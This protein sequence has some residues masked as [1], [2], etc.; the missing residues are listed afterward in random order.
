MYREKVKAFLEKRKET[1]KIELSEINKLLLLISDNNKI[2]EKI[3]IKKERKKQIL[4]EQLPEADFVFNNIPT[5]DFFLSNLK[6]YR[7]WRKMGVVFV[8]TNSGISDKLLYSL[9]KFHDSKCKRQTIDGLAK[10]Y[11][12][13]ISD[14]DLKYNEKGFYKDLTKPVKITVV[15][16]VKIKVEKSVKINVEKVELT[17]MQKLALKLEKQRK[18]DPYKNTASSGNKLIT[19]RIL[20]PINGRKEVIENIDD[21]TISVIPNV[22]KY[23]SGDSGH[24]L[25]AYITRNYRRLRIVVKGLSTQ[26]VWDFDNTMDTLHIEL[27][28]WLKR[29]SELN[30][31]GDNEKFMSWI[32]NIAK[33]LKQN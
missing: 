5:I 7:L 16:V 29:E 30:F 12:V 28:N 3:E 9:E 15:K 17:K 24:C 18:A 2:S 23:C 10:T 13:V 21:A 33:E 19:P 25:K 14:L 22:L 27:E 4:I 1:L 11:G 8:A 26:R 31:H 32:Y 6:N 20:L